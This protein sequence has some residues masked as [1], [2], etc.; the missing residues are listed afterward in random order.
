M[1]YYENFAPSINNKSAH[2]ENYNLFYNPKQASK[3]G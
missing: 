2:E 3:Y 1:E